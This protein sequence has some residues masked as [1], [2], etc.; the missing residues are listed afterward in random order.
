MVFCG[1]DGIIDFYNKIFFTLSNPTEQTVDDKICASFLIAFAI[2]IIDRIM[3]PDSRFDNLEIIEGEFWLTRAGVPECLQFCHTIIDM[4]NVMVPAPRLTIEC[5]E[6][7]LFLK[8][9]H[10]SPRN[11]KPKE[12][13]QKKTG[14]LVCRLSEERGRS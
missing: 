5:G 6:I 9:N 10:K 11:N 2:R 4:N 13:S 3:I 1:Y 7:C 12:C 8:R 14:W